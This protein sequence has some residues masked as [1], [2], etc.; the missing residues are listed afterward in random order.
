ME[1][2]CQQDVDSRLVLEKDGEYPWQ[3]LHG[4]FG[5]ADFSS[6]PD[7]HWTLLI[8]SVNNFETAAARFLAKFDFIP[9]WRV[10]DLMISYAKDEGGVGPHL[11][12]YDVFL[13]QAKGERRWE[14]NSHQYNEDDFIEGLDLRIIDNFQVEEEYL[15]S[16]GDM[17]YLPPGVAHHGIAIGESLTF[18]IGFRAPTSLELIHG[19]LDDPSIINAENRYSD[20]ELSLQTHTGEISADSMNML[21]SMVQDL[22]QREENLTDYIG[23]HLSTVSEDLET[24][25]INS[26]TD[27][28]S[29]KHHYS[30]IP[31][32]DVS[33][34]SRILFFKSET[35]YMLFAN[36]KSYS[37]PE[38]D[39]VFIEQLSAGGQVENP[40]FT[41]SAS[42]E[43]ELIIWDLQKSG[44][45]SA[46]SDP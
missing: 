27:F 40:I 28:E 31:Y 21:V 22:T 16:S 8:N 41:L 13:F 38:S 37:L 1:L 24:D 32:L 44:V 5:A 18:S 36:G 2:S 34:S 26:G 12:N 10:D 6:L 46:K 20:P 23:R 43:M 35:G 25:N 4:P 39:R 7:S 42:R 17:L 15:L 30:E 29:F 14:I 11:D 3:V 45:I 9:R 33:I 19:Y